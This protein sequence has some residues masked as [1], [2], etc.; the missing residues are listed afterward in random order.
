MAGIVK[1]YGPQYV[2]PTVVLAGLF[3]VFFGVFRL[4]WTIEYIS[5]PVVAGFINAFALYLIKSQTKVFTSIL[6]K[7]IPLYSS[8]G[9]ALTTASITQLLPKI[10][11]AVP[12]PLV[13]LTVATL[14]S[15]IFNL[16]VKTLVQ[17]VPDASAFSGGLASLPKLIPNPFGFSM[18]SNMISV[19]VTA[20]LGVA[21]ISIIETVIASNLVRI[22]YRKGSTDKSDD[23][24]KL[25]MGLGLGSAAAAFIGGFGGCGLIPNTLLNA[26][27]GGLSNISQ[28]SFA[29]CLALA[30]LCFAPL[31]AKIPVSAIAGIMF[32]VGFNTVEWA[33]T[34]H[35]FQAALGIFQN[36]VSSLKK[37]EAFIDVL[38][39]I[40][41]FILCF[42]VDM[43][44]GIFAGV[45]ITQVGKLVGGVGHA[46]SH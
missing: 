29:I 36:N 27:S 46:K 33:E 20:A 19:I 21:V 32:V 40:V 34:K 18:S 13:G 3:E 25:S 38:A 42:K 4:G 28:F 16:P 22:N 31:I 45:A 30:V 9:L 8:I 1:S 14:I 15:T 6:S 41:A 10:T 5:E 24:N 44:T 12:A 43:M 39:H 17:T 37:K 2:L 11:K 26:R 23:P 35:V 7:T